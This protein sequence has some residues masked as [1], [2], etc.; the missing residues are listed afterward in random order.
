[1]PMLHLLGPPQYA[2]EEPFPLER[3]ADNHKEISLQLKKFN[4][5]IYYRNAPQHVKK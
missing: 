3:K 1:M 2:I 5:L 4:P